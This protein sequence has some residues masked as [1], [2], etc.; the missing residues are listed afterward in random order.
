MWSRSTPPA[1]RCLV[2]PVEWDSPLPVIIGALFVIVMARANGTYWLGRGLIAGAQKTRLAHWVD[3]PSYQRA[4]RLL[5]KWGAPLVTVSF[6]TVG[7]QTLVNLAAGTARMSLS[8]YLPAVT[9][10]CIIWAV[11]YGTVGLVG[12]EAFLTAY[13]ENPTLT[14]LVMGILVASLA[15]YIYMKVRTQRGVAQ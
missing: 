1:D 11:V 10:G 7:F 8:R 12:F 6:L 4:Q 15:L 13:D 3:K 14:L 9:L 2:N 5:Q